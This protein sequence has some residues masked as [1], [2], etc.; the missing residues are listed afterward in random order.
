MQDPNSC[1]GEISDDAPKTCKQIVNKINKKVEEG[2]V[3]AARV[4]S[5]GDI[6]LTVDTLKT[7]TKLERGGEWL[8]SLK[9]Y[10]AR[11]N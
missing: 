4:L 11:V 3:L 9:M 5:S 1:Y 7:K 8:S 2:K 6:C 10:G